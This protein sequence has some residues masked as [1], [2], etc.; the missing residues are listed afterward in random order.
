MLP[1]LRS[2]PFGWPSGCCAAPDPGESTARRLEEEG[3]VLE[4][5]S[6][7][8]AL[9]LRFRPAPP[10]LASLRMSCLLPFLGVSFAPALQGKVHHATSIRLAAYT[11]SRR[12]RRTRSI[13]PQCPVSLSLALLL[14]RLCSVRMVT[15]PCIRNSAPGLFPR[16]PERGRRT[17]TDRVPNPN[18]TPIH[19][20]PRSAGLHSPPAARASAA[21]SS[22]PPNLRPLRAPARPRSSQAAF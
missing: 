14:L 18:P 16:L 17:S 12:L 21:P 3:R 11:A 9:R 20:H 7:R 10:R 5:R 19:L 6:T 13:A 2:L 8:A 22:R 1:C 15:L 4:A